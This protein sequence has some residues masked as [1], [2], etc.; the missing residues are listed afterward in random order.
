MVA[1][2][3]VESVSHLPVNDACCWVFILAVLP[4]STI[5]PGEVDATTKQ[6]QDSDEAHDS[7]HNAA[8]LAATEAMM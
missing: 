8:N 2:S 1:P 5:A 6:D 7:T 4:V 3:I